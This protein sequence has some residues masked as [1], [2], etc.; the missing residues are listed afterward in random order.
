MDE[1]WRFSKGMK[2]SA[3][4]NISRRCPR[5]SLEYTE[6]GKLHRVEGPTNEFAN[7]DRMW[8]KN[9][10]RSFRSNQISE[11]RVG[12]PAIEC[13]NGDWSWWEN[14][15]RHRIGGSAIE[16]TNGHKEWWENDN[17]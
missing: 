7:G 11:H 12:G 1:E 9:D 5:L 17:G 8:Y 2:S 16:C 15:N 4:V 3:N 13:A 10:N 6:G 14:G